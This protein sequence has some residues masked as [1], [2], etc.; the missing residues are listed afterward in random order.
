MDY[1]FTE[2]EN[3]CRNSL[4]NVFFPAG[5]QVID[6]LAV[7]GLAVLRLAAVQLG[8][9][10]PGF[11]VLFGIDPFLRPLF[12]G[13]VG[14]IVLR[15]VGP[16]PAIHLSL[17]DPHFCVD[18]VQFPAEQVET[19]FGVAHVGEGGR[20]EVQTDQA[21]GRFILFFLV[22]YDKKTLPPA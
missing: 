13:A 20:P 10:T 12:D 9:L 2:L 8:E 3:L 7:K 19:S 6:Q 4:L 17:D 18:V 11:E 1:Y 16:A 14:V 22:G 21:F 15:V 5:K